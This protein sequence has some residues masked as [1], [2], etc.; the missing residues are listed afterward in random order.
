MRCCLLIAA[1][2]IPAASPGLAQGDPG[3]YRVVGGAGLVTCQDW[4]RA[5][6][7]GGV[8]LAQIESWVAGYLSAYNRHVAPD[9]N[10]LAGRDPQSLL[11]WGEKFCRKNPAMTIAAASDAMV[12]ELNRA[13]EKK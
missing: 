5:R 4:L 3:K 10:I 12:F 6:E 13:K 2:A 9:G 7:S 1:A 11:D 8:V